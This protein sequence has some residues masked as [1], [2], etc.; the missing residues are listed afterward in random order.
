MANISTQPE[1]IVLEEE[2]L[3]ETLALAKENGYDDGTQVIEKFQSIKGTQ[4]D[5]YRCEARLG[6][7]RPVPTQ[8]LTVFV[9]ESNKIIVHIDVD[10]GATLNY[11]RLKEAREN[12]FKISP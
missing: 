7:I 10:S 9:D 1:E 4:P 8:V 2:C 11:V 12:N 6:Y 3:D 5:F